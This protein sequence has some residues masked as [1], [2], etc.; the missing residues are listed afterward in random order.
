[1]TK[2]SSKYDFG[3]SFV[4]LKGLFVR[5]DSSITSTNGI[6][7]SNVLC[8]IATY[9]LT[10][11]SG[12]DFDFVFLDNVN[13]SAGDVVF[14]QRTNNY[15][16]DTIQVVNSHII[17]EDGDKFIVFT[18]QNTG[19]DDFTGNVDIQFLVIKVSQ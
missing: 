17:D 19:S 16:S 12:N 15:S 5:G 13:V 6:A 3:K 10:E 8:G 1:M 4:E 9:A 14:A 2:N 7:E 11:L 18:V